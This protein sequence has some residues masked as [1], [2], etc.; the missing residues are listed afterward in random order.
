MQGTKFKAKI[1]FRLALIIDVEV[2]KTKTS[3]LEI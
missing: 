2:A 3:F 1:F